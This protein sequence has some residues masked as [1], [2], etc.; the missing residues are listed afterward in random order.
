MDSSL[1]EFD[2]NVCW[3]GDL[4]AGPGSE[5]TGFVVDW[6]SLYDFLTRLEAAGIPAVRYPLA[7]VL[8][9]ALLAKLAG[10]DRLTGI[11][12]WVHIARRL[13]RGT[14]VAAPPS[15]PPDYVQPDP[16]VNAV[17]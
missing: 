6:G 10:E 11:A 7:W 5:G 17:S 16:G 2:V 3:P 12:E 14:G 15:A 8:T 4:D 1:A 9:M 13:W